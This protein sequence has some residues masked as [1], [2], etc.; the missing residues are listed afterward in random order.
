M[1]PEVVQN[2]CPQQL[3]KEQ[4]QLKETQKKL[5]TNVTDMLIHLYNGKPTSDF[6]GHYATIAQLLDTCKR[7]QQPISRQAGANL[8]TECLF[9]LFCEQIE[10]IVGTVKDKLQEDAN[11]DALVTIVQQEVVVS[12]PVQNP[13]TK[14][15]TQTQDVLVV[16]PY[17][18]FQPKFDEIL[19]AVGDYFDLFK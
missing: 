16:K 3:S 8:A 7:L 14:R 1:E 2:P 17:P 19:S 4:K 13:E 9:E 11:K 12:G 5:Q 18:D 15:K 10:S 6:K